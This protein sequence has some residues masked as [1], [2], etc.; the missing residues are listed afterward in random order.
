MAVIRTSN[1]SG[2]CLQMAAAAFSPADATAYFM[3]NN[4]ATAPTAAS[5]SQF[6]V[7]CPSSGTVRACY[8]FV[9]SVTTTGTNEQSTIALRLNNTT[10]T[11][12]SSTL[13]NSVAGA[14]ASNTALN[15]SVVQGD[16]LEIKWTTPTWATNPT[17]VRI[18]AAIFIS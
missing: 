11:T 1:T 15:I 9:N 10:D 12:V 13:D 3:G 6:R 16:Y 17:G 8:I 5:G 4:P 2:Y 18:S 14:V 7:Y